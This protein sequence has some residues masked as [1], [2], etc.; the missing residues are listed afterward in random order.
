MSRSGRVL[1]SAMLMLLA[2][3]G[4]VLSPSVAQE[5]KLRTRVVR[6]EG[7]SYTDVSATELARM[8]KKKNFPLINVHIPYEGDLPGTDLSVAF[9][10]IESN[11]S[12][13]PAAKNARVVLYCMSGRM[14]VIAA[15]RLVKLGY[16]DVWNLDGG[17]IAWEQSGY[18]LVRGGR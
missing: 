9:D 13:L 2:V 5:D 6:V 7:G 17:M 3:G 14:S 18:P 10:R 8:L 16:T 4:G 15:R 1:M 12:R 11:L